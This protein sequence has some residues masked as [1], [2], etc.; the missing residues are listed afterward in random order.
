[1]ILTEK[2]AVMKCLKISCSMFSEFLAD[3]NSQKQK[4]FQGKQALR[5]FNEIELCDPIVF[6]QF[7][8][9]LLEKAKGK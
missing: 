3:E 1:M 7:A 4:R 6:C 5:N 2:E 9:F 8:N